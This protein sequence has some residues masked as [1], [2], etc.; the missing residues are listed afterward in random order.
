MP[1]HHAAA[2]EHAGED[3]ELRLGQRLAE[4]ADLEPEAHVRAVG[5]VARHR[6]VVGHARP[7]RRGDL[8]AGRLVDAREHALDRLDHVLL[9]HEAHLEVELGELG[10]AVGAQVLV[11]EAAGDLVVALEAGHHQ[12]LLEQLRRLRQRV[13]RARV[14]ARGDEEVARALGRGARH[15]R[16]LHLE[17][18]V[19]VEVV[20]DRAVDGVADRHRA[21]H[22]GA[23]QVDDAVA[24]PQQLVDRRLL[25]DRERRRER[26]G[27]RLRLGDL[28]LDLAGV[29]LRVDVAL[30]AAHDRAGGGDDV[31]GAQPL[32]QRVGLGRRLGVEDELDDPGAVA[33]VDE[34]QPA[35]VAAAMHPAGDADG[36]VDVAGAQLAGPGVAE[37]V[38][39]RRP[40]RGLPPRM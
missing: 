20:A 1:A 33:Q 29:E 19:R 17:E 6:L 4:V 24:Q 10:L 2:R 32:G 14:H 22:A 12:H 30:L 31:L 3:A 15:D 5:A 9:V 36:R 40:H 13:E 35:V 23:A 8:E 39:A 28:E 38:G 11:P 16:R 25:V 7:R 27:E 21:L 37:G 34:D 26:L 18:V